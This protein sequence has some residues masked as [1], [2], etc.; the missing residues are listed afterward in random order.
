MK[1]EKFIEYISISNKIHKSN[2]EITSKDYYGHFVDYK[3]IN[4][5][6]LAK[7]HK[8]KRIFKREVKRFFKMRWLRCLHYNK[9]GHMKNDK[10]IVIDM[11]L[12]NYD[13][14]ED[15]LIKFLYKELNK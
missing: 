12:N 7:E 10:E 9:F 4:N 11:I 15:D 6:K 14:L 1:K 2:I 13:K 8:P 5:E 3:I